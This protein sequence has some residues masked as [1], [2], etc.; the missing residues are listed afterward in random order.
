MKGNESKPETNEQQ[1]KKMA[2][3]LWLRYYNRTL[4]EQGVINERTYRQMDRK[5]DTWKGP[6]L[7]T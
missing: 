1:R 3:E 2:A 5:I 6:T 4:Y 7:S